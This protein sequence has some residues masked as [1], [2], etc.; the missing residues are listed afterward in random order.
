MKIGS[1][2]GNT[3]Y[4]IINKDLTKPTKVNKMAKQTRLQEIR[5]GFY[6]LLAGNRNAPPELAYAKPNKSIVLIKT[7]NNP[8]FEKIA[9]SRALTHLIP[10]TEAEIRNELEHR[11]DR[12]AELKELCDLRYA[13]STTKCKSGYEYPEPRSEPMIVRDAQTSPPRKPEDSGI[14]KAARIARAISASYR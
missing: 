13:Q 7:L 11:V 9:L 4:K 1:Q 14:V 8:G 5:E 3:A 2:Q 6:Y 10:M 12:L